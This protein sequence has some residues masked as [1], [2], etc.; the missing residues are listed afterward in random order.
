[1]LIY[2]MPSMGAFTPQQLSSV[3]ATG[4]IWLTEPEIFTP[5]PLQ[6]MFPNLDVDY[7]MQNN[8]I[9]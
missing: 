8:N 3:A 9:F 7:Y 6:Q 4:T 1:M 2:Y 5:G